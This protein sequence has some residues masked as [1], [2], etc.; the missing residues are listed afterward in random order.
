LPTIVVYEEIDRKPIA[1]DVRAFSYNPIEIDDPDKSIAT[2]R[3]AVKQ[4]KRDIDEWRT[5]SNPV[6]VFYRTPIT[7][8]SPAAGVAQGM[9]QNFV[10]PTG[11]MLSDLHPSTNE[12]LYELI[13]DGQP[14]A[15][16]IE[17]RRSIQIHVVIPSELRFVL[18]AQVD[19]VGREL[20]TAEIPRPRRPLTMKARMDEQGIWQLY[21]IPTAM[22]V[23]EKSIDRRAN[24]IN[25][26][27]NSTEWKQLEDQEIIRFHIALKQWIDEHPSDKFR[28]RVN[29]IEFDVKGRDPKMQWLYEIWGL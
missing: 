21:D 3:R 24:Q 7:N 26:Q 27:K 25:V 9:F 28:E 4:V 19:T 29:I 6:T 23:L 12:H 16:T 13:I 22:N 14:I 8:I 20:S 2:L 5:P 15:P 17:A 1:F 11:T 10:E 18:Q